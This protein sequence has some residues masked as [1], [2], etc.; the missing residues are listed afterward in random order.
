MTPKPPFDPELEALMA[1]MPSNPDMRP[2]ILPIMRTGLE[3]VFTAD[4]VISGKPIEHEEVQIQVSGGEITLSIFRPTSRSDSQ[5]LGPGIYFIH[6]GGLVVG[7]QFLGMSVVAEWI[8]KFEATCVSVEYRLAPEH[9]Y[10][11]PLED[12]YA[13]LRWVGD[14]F[15]ELGIDESRLMLAGQSAGG[16]LAAAVAIH[17]RNQG[18]PQICAQVLMCPMLDHRNITVSS[19]QFLTEGT[20]RGKN[21]QVAWACYLGE[22]GKAEGEQV[23]ILASPALATAADLSN[24]PTTFIDVGTAETFR[25][26]DIAYA[27]RLLEAGVQVELHA[28]PGGIHG[29]DLLLPTCKLSQKAIQTRTAW[30][31]RIL[32]N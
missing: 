10:P 32:S 13:G 6:G 18:G 24:L 11:I 7:N 21:N 19:Q 22:H 2:D 31:E 20:W 8:E 5:K 12:C 3:Q 14:H 29:F 27:N 23:D 26:E 9:P 16:G 30:V 28:W 15:S 1:K 4:A 17:A 25:D